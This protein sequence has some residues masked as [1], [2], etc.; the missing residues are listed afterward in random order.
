M[1]TCCYAQTPDVSLGS[2]WDILPNLRCA[3]YNTLCKPTRQLLFERYCAEI[4]LMD[5]NILPDIEFLASGQPP[6]LMTS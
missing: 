5:V 1:E 6:S 2:Y 3:N 4:N